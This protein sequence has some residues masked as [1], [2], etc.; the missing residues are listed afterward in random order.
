MTVVPVESNSNAKC[1]NCGAEP[2]G[3][4]FCPQCGQR[5]DLL[6]LSARGL[7][8]EASEA[9]FKVDRKFA[10]TVKA[11]LMPG[12]LTIDYLEGRRARYAKPLSLY[13]VCAGVF[14][15]ARTFTGQATPGVEQFQ[16][17]LA[18][19]R[20]EVSDAGVADEPAPSSVW[21][22]LKQHPEKAAAVL[23]GTQTPKGQLSFVAALTAGLALATRKRRFLLSEHLIFTLQVQA[24][25]NLFGAG[26]A[27]LRVS[28]NTSTGLSLIYDAAAFVRV[29]G[30]GW[31]GS[32]WRF[33]WAMTISYV[34]L[35]VGVLF[36]I[37][38]SVW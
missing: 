18:N 34:L 37:V 31:W 27:L 30:F 7:F 21:G 5:N 13:L 24:F 15:L 19:A 14:Y 3:G 36:A 33:G 32:L 17:G 6:R 25:S 29:Y 8:K 23:D 20:I 16:L 11:L 4:A 9:I 1:P 12:Q 22:R 10:A 38:A 26:C 35:M 28:D 2:A